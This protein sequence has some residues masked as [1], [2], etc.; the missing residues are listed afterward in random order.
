MSPRIP[1][2][3]L[4]VLITFLESPNCHAPSCP[5]VWETQRMSSPPTSPPRC[6]LLGTGLTQLPLVY[7]WPFFPFFTASWQQ[8]KATLLFSTVSHHL[9]PSTPSF[10]SL[11]ASLSLGPASPQPLK[12]AQPRPEA[13]RQGSTDHLPNSLPPPPAHKNTLVI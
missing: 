3:K 10:P 5:A 4:Q 12:P 6:S 11:W 9:L 7:P 8:G 13:L 2:G 1:L